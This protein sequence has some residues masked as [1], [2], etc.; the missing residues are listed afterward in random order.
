VYGQ[1]GGSKWGLLH[2]KSSGIAAENSPWGGRKA[3][4]VAGEGGA[5]GNAEPEGKGI[6]MRRS[7]NLQGDIHRRVRKRGKKNLI[8]SRGPYLPSQSSREKGQ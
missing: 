2:S 5:Q 3:G 1:K 8:S 4:E 7:L 6:S